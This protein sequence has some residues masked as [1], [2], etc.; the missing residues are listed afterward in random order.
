MDERVRLGGGREDV[1]A[2]DA[3]GGRNLDIAKI[4]LIAGPRIGLGDMEGERRGCALG[5]L[6]HL[7][8]ILEI[9]APLDVTR[10]F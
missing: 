3:A 4:G 5:R 6:R 10:P 2:A 1:R 9:S 8:P 7:Y